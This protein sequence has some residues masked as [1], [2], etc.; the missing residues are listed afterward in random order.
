MCVVRWIT[1]LLLACLGGCAQRSQGTA[2]GPVQHY[3]L[4]GQI[5]ALDARHQTARIRHR[6]IEGWMEAMTMDFPVKD[7]REFRILHT[8]DQITATVFVQDPDYWI[9]EIHNSYSP[10]RPETGK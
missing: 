4:A 9:G 8:G 10:G 7:E 3:Q 6:K 1:V 5:V 2:S